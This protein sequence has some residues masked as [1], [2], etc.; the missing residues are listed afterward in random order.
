MILLLRGAVVKIL[1]YGLVGGQLI[2]EALE[3][4]VCSFDS[5]LHTHGKWIALK[6]RAP[7]SRVHACGPGLRIDSATFIHNNFFAVQI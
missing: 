4:H 7:L 2:L 5:G 3:T 6:V 1:E